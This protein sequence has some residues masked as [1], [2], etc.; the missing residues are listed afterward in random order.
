MNLDNIMRSEMS[1]T[2]KDKYCMLSFIMQNLK[3]GIN[4]YNKTE[5]D[6]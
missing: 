3:N 4:E 5:T 2:E 6:L 1:Q